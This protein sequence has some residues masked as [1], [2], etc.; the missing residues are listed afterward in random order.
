MG[1]YE[2]LVH[3]GDGPAG[4][5][6][7]TVGRHLAEK[8]VPVLDTGQGYRAVTEHWLRLQEES[9]YRFDRND[10]EMV[11]AWM[12]EFVDDLDKLSD[13]ATSLPEQVRFGVDGLYIG[14]DRIDPSEL[15]KVLYSDSIA[16]SI[17]FI[18]RVGAIRKFCGSISVRFVRDAVAN[19][20]EEVYLDGRTE[21]QV[22]VR[23][24]Q[25]R[26]LS[27]RFARLALPAFFS[28]DDTEA[29]HRLLS[30]DKDIEY[31]SLPD[32]DPLVEDRKRMARERNQRDSDPENVDPMRITSVHYDALT[33]EPTRDAI[34]GVLGVYQDGSD[35]R[36][37]LFDTTDSTVEESR[38]RYEAWRSAVVD[39][40]RA[41]M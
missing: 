31:R 9:E 38:G 1:R 30:R 15:S 24:F 28:V 20:A 41:G 10:K 3:T 34:A 16:E 13:F 12:G 33:D 40:L 27:R 11:N 35:S 32:D 25:S 36:H 26:E 23:S 8:G 39:F 29:A 17:S 14:D 21:R 19:D 2:V 4:S 37:V 18:A 7:G 6:K 22:M 5:G